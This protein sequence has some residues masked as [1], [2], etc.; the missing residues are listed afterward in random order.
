MKINKANLNFIGELNLPIYKLKYK[1]NKKKT[2]AVLNLMLCLNHAD[3]NCNCTVLC[4][5]QNTTAILAFHN[6][7]VF[8]YFC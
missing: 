6:I 3:D 2:S 1:K 4:L 7:Y 8:V 5:P